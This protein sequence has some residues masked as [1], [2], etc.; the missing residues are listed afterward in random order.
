MHVFIILCL[1]PLT[2]DIDDLSAQLHLE[3]GMA[4]IQQGLLEQAEEEFNQ[5]LDISDDYSTAVLG[6]G[7]VHSLRQSWDSAK[8]YLLQYIDACPD[9][10]RGFF[11]LSRLYLFTDKPDSAAFMSDSAFIRAPTNTDVW[12]QSGVAWLEMGDMDSAEM[13]FA[14]GAEAEGSTTLQSLVYLASVYRRTSR[15]AEAREL[16]I[17]ASDAGYAPACWELAKVYLGWKDYLRAG[18]AISR[19][20]IL[21]PVGYYADSAIL[22]LEELGESGDYIP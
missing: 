13:W 12:L 8:D 4:L 10:Y 3:T 2:I 21:S 1:I 19:Y 6:L 17:P 22:V 14:K 18:D 15:A 20:L 5:V 16:L 9:D 11:E 7:M